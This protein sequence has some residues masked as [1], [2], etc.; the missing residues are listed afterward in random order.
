MSSSTEPPGAAQQP[1]A[2]RDPDGWQPRD[3]ARQ[4]DVAQRPHGRIPDFFIVGNPKCGT[5]ALY[6]M[7]K[8][9]PQIYMPDFKEPRFFA[10]DLPSRQQLS[11][12]SVL[13]RTFEDYLSLFAPAR[14]EQRAGEASPS[15]LRSSDAARAIAEVQPGARIIAILR[16]PASFL[17]SLHLEF[18]RNHFETETELRRAIALEPAT[19]LGAPA[20]DSSPERRRPRYT[21][22]VRYVEQLRRYH[23][24]FAPEQVL[25]L[26]YDDFRRDNEATVRR[27]LRFLDVEDTLP[28]EVIEA[29]PSAGVRSR[30][31]DDWIRALYA[32]RNPLT[33]ALKATI[34]ATTPKRVHG[35]LL[36][37]VRRRLVYGRPA[38]PDEQLMR[39]LRAR[40]KPEVVALSEYL[41]RDLVSLW[42]YDSVE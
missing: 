16:E 15:Y 6:E 27:V 17:R 42:G 29:N 10:S 37:S 38:P 12:E 9:H 33:R 2:A 18:L 34:K 30:R 41:D 35:D 32:E 21:D 8:R 36:R 23:D 28:I 22:R 26:I 3:A 20:P 39:E 7:L 24:A 40:F 4:P 13:P 25:V 31:M 11:A 19:P 5:T 1:D 14:P